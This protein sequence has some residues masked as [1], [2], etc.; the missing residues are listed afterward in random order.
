MIYFRYTRA[1]TGHAAFHDTDL[2]GTVYRQEAK[3]D[4]R[5]P[6][7]SRARLTVSGMLYIQY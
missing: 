6:W 4:E 5:G 7:L 1:I 2:A 3:V